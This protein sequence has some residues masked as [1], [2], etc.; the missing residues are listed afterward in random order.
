MATSSARLNDTLQLAKGVADI[1]TACVQWITALTAGASAAVQEVGSIGGSSAVVAVAV[2]TCPPVPRHG[3]LFIKAQ[4]L[5]LEGH[6]IAVAQEALQSMPRD[7]S[8][9]VRRVVAVPLLSI[10]RQMTPVESIGRME[11]AARRK[12][13][14][15]IYTAR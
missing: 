4:G 1:K 7:G 15:S 10:L 9:T 5:S 2:G 13:A 14:S 3:D 6:P 8:I 11:Q 12:Q